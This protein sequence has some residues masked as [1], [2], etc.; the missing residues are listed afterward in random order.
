MKNENDESDLTINIYK[1]R[2]TTIYKE[3]MVWCGQRQYYR[4]N[5]LFWRY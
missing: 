4:W 1:K 2:G 3:S 5:F